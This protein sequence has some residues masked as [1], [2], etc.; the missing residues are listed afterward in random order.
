M[1]SLPKALTHLDYVNTEIYIII[2][3]LPIYILQE[4][5]WGFGVLGLVLSLV[6]VG[7]STN[8]KTNY[9]F[10][11]E[12]LTLIVSKEYDDDD[13]QGSIQNFLFKSICIVINLQ[14]FYESE[15]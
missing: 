8:D 3:I 1:I 4:F 10:F 15:V 12:T 11:Y 5:L 7:S 14:L 2:T 13:S 6:I 9:Y